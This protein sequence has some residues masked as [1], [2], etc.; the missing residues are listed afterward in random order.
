MTLV[1][2]LEAVRGA[3]IR[4]IAHLPAD[5]PE[6]ELR[7]FED[8]ALRLG[9]LA[10]EAHKQLPDDERRQCLHRHVVLIHRGKATAE[11]VRWVRELAHASPRAHA[12]VAIAAQPDRVHEGMSGYLG[13][14]TQAELRCLGLDQAELRSL[15]APRRNNLGARASRLWQRGRM[16]SAKRW[17]AAAVERARRT[18]D[19]PG[20]ALA[21]TQLLKYT[22]ARSDDAT[23]PLIARGRR[24][25]MSL[26]QLA[27]RSH[28]VTGLA[29][30]W[31]T[32]GEFEAAAA[33]LAA[34]DVECQLSGV[35][36]PPWIRVP[37]CELAC[38][39]GCWDLADRWAR[40]AGH[41][42]WR[43]VVAFARRDWAAAHVLDAAASQP[44]ADQ[45]A[46][47]AEGPSRW[48]DIL[49]LE[50]LRMAGADDAATEWIQKADAHPRGRSEQLLWHWSTRRVE[51][52]RAAALDADIRRLG[53]EG[54]RR[55][56]LRRQDMHMWAG[57]SS[58]L[59]QVH[60]ADDAATA[61]RRACRWARE[62]TG[63]DGVGIVSADGAVIACEPETL[64]RG[65]GP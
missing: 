25:L 49:V 28:V 24:L 12:V 43:A 51:T 52:G 48:R 65:D 57:V 11:S 36:V 5:V 45:D 29:G 47:P 7:V 34:V 44:D 17:T 16:A 6:E 59:T 8:E 38:W 50:R 39:Q 31:M 15:R 18:R 27:A 2:Q 32:I 61:M 22:A 35:R 55:W 37:Q 46:W 4:V 60:E 41:L 3:G 63:V 9:Y 33:A 20:A 42:E 13:L 21:F 26:E 58:L 62:Y 19:E 40:E 53:A 30:L 56:G 64:R 23:V 54:I 10:V 1:E 14:E